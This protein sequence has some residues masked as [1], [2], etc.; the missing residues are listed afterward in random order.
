MPI[1]AKMVIPDTMKNLLQNY[2]DNL[3]FKECVGNDKD[4]SKNI[5][6]DNHI[7]SKRRQYIIHYSLVWKKKSVVEAEWNNADKSLSK[8]SCWKVHA[9]P[10][11][12]R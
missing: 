9:N 6:Q 10:D 5:L 4:F 2:T 8:Q 7:V 12:S 1:V 3:L 11:D